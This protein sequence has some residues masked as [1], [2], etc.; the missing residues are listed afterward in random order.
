MKQIYAK[1]QEIKLQVETLDDLWY[2]SAIISPGDFIKGKTLRKIKLGGEDDRKAK[3]IKKPITLKILV[4]RI[5][6]SKTSDILRVSGKI[7]EGPEDVKLDSYHTFNVELSSTITIIKE[8]WLKFQL[9]KLKESTQ[10]SKTNILILVHDREEA[11]FALLKK[12]GYDLLSSVSGDVQKKVDT[13]VKESSFY[14]LLIKQLKAYD[15]KYKFSNII[16]ASPAFWKE[17]LLKKVSDSEL[18]S[19]II[20]AT[21]SS[22]GNNGIDEVLKRPETKKALQ[23]ERA[24]KEMSAVEALLEE[25]S[26]EGVGVYGLKQT[27]NAVFAGAVKELLITDKLIMRSREKGDYSLL[28]SILKTVEKSKGSI[29]IISSDHEGGQKLD[30]LGGIG[31]ILRYKLNY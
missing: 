1:K 11:Y 24:S 17:D 27:E 14:P 23:R 21:C 13:E 31:A 20:T 4:E 28:D 15:E 29:L 5:E 26:K 19:K 7:K 9:D 10:D 22:V 12:Y 8:E 2:L 30:G 25:I 18:K 16:I 6:F 3:I